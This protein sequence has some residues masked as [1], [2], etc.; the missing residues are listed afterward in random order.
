MNII[1]A[2]ESWKNVVDSDVAT[3]GSLEDLFSNAV[4]AAVLLLGVALLVMFVVA[5]FSFLFSGGDPKK[6]EKAKGTLTN[7]I[8]GLVIIVSAYIILNLIHAFTGV[9]VTTFRVSLF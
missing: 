2:A 3:F 8:I 5:G 7:A 4:R 6:L 1:H 9:D